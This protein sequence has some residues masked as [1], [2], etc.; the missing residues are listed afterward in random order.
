MCTT[1]CKKMHAAQFLNIA[2]LRE[3]FCPQWPLWYLI[4]T[5][6]NANCSCNTDHDSRL[7]TTNTQFVLHW[8]TL[9]TWLNCQIM[10]CVSSWER[11]SKNSRLNC[12]DWKYWIDTA[13]VHV[14]GQNCYGTQS[15]LKW[16]VSNPE[17]YWQWFLLLI[18]TLVLL[19]ILVLALILVLVFVFLYY[20][21]VWNAESVEVGAWQS[22]HLCRVLLRKSFVS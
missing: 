13:A 10:R 6:H 22:W 14:L 12:L 1:H 9:L 17:W 5:E 8:N 7:H 15:L 21:L 18:L 4:F 11:Q 20:E 16:R 2:A 3:Q 19:L